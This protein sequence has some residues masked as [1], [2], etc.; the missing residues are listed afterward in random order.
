MVCHVLSASRGAG[1]DHQKSAEAIVVARKRNEG[2]N[3]SGVESH[4]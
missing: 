2:P 1:K 3:L 4:A